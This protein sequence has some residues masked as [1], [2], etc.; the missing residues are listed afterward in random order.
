M[1]AELAQ[2]T[3]KKERKFVAEKKE[4]TNHRYAKALS[5][6]TLSA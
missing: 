6:Q 4:N 5:T 1:F 2:F 3:E